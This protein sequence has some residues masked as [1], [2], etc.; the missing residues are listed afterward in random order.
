ME[1]YHLNS[2]QII[3]IKEINSEIIKYITCKICSFIPIIPKK[4]INCENIFCAKCIDQFSS[5]DEKKNTCPLNCENP[6]YKSLSQIEL[7][8]YFYGLIIACSNRKFGCFYSANY[9]E[10]DEILTHESNC[11]YKCSQCNICK[12]YVLQSK[13]TDHVLSCNSMSNC[14]HE[15]QELYKTIIEI[16]EQNKSL[17][18]KLDE[19]EQIILKQKREIE[20]LKSTKYNYNEFNELKLEYNYLKYENNLIKKA[21]EE[22]NEKTVRDRSEEGKHEKSLTEIR[23]EIEILKIKCKNKIRDIK[24][25]NS[26]IKK[27]IDQMSSSATKTL[28]DSKALLEETFKTI[29]TKRQNELTTKFSMAHQEGNFQF[30]PQVTDN[31]NLL[32]DFESLNDSSID[33]KKLTNEY[34]WEN[35]GLKYVHPDNVDHTIIC[36]KEL[37]KHLKATI[38]VTPCEKA[39]FAFGVALKKVQTN[40]KHFMW[41]TEAITDCYVYNSNGMVSDKEDSRKYGETFWQMPNKISIIIDKD[42]NISFEK[43][44]DNLG[45]AFRNV[46][47]PFYLAASFLYKGYEAEIIEVVEL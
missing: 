39:W 22:L 24:L 10:L 11:G 36:H 19:F 8:S 34:K 40:N 9:K 37:P 1:N 6:Y 32:N 42:N 26:S 16:K 15:N 46:K 21:L 23:S 30:N 3:N 14:D 7:V 4:E 43:N 13:Y 18:K 2:S 45:I 17:R 20:T 41:C 25:E 5:L 27:S 28:E 38:L 31:L 33:A 47:G 35:Y 12:L 29:L 44:G